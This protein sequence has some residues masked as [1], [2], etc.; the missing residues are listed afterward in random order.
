[1]T[2]TASSQTAPRGVPARPIHEQQLDDLRRLVSAHPEWNKV[3]ISSALRQAGAH[4]GPDNQEAFLHS[5]PLDKVERFLGKLTINSVE[6]R[7]ARPESGTG[8]IASPELKWIVRADAELPNG[9]HPAYVLTF[10]PF[11]GKLTDLDQ[12]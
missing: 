8:A 5:L 7:L 4:Y 12:H 1:M 3:Q 9:A 11:E 2:D 6:F 10:E